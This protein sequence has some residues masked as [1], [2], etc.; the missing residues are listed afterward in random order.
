MLQSAQALIWGMYPPPPPVDGR[1]QVIDIHTM[2]KL[3]DN[4][5]PN[6]VYACPI[7]LFQLIQ[8]NPCSSFVGCRDAV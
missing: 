7:C 2:D 8:L 5:E 1:S 4:I 3:V 6:P